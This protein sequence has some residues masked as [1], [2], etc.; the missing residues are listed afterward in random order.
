MSLGFLE[1]RTPDTD[2]LL[3][4]VNSGIRVLP[5]LHRMLDRA[6][7]LRCVWGYLVTKILC[8][9]PNCW[10]NVVEVRKCFLTLRGYA[11]YVHSSWHLHAQREPPVPFQLKTK[12]VKSMGSIW[13]FQHCSTY[14]SFIVNSLAVLLWSCTSCDPL[15][16]IYPVSHLLLHL[17]LSLNLAKS[18]TQSF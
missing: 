9:V 4:Y 3:V 14:M 6:E 11:S 5:H 13:V 17:L 1:S 8:H 12:S 15:L 16:P 10:I 18:L 2:L 7:S